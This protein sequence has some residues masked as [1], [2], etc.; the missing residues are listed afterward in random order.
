MSEIKSV[1]VPVEAS[2]LLAKVR[3]MKADGY[4][5]VRPAQQSARTDISRFFIHLIRTIH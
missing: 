5:L 1:F 3:S 2:E 4:R